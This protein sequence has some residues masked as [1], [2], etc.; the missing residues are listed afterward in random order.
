[1]GLNPL[2]HFITASGANVVPIYNMHILQREPTFSHN[3]HL[4][5]LH[6]ALGLCFGNFC[7]QKARK[8]REKREK[9]VRKM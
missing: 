6:Y 2:I 7:E 8:A 9:N 4:S 1:M 5:I 3:K